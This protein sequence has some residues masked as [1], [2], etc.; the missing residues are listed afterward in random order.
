MPA[1]SLS[2]LREPTQVWPC[3]HWSRYSSSTK[4]SF[5]DP[6]HP[7]TDLRNQ[8]FYYLSLRLKTNPWQVHEAQYSPPT[9]G[10]YS[11]T[12]FHNG[13]ASYLNMKV[14]LYLQNL[15]LYNFIQT[16]ANLNYKQVLIL[17]WPHRMYTIYKLY[18]LT[19][20]AENVSFH[21]PLSTT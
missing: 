2:Q 14:H 6:S 1:I 13:Q 7:K 15:A 16:T 5:S 8:K 20:L 4:A 21:E 11:H 10:T 19:N 18:L 3:S 12:G 9:N 17:Q